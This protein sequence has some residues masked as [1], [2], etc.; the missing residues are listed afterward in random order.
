MNDWLKAEMSN[1][2]ETVIPLIGDSVA[3]YCR[4]RGDGKAWVSDLGS[5]DS[6]EEEDGLFWESA[7]GIDS[8]FDGMKF[9]DILQDYE[10]WF[11]PVP[12][13]EAGRFPS[14]MTRPVNEKD[15]LTVFDTGLEV[16]ELL[17]AGGEEKGDEYGRPDFP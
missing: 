7:F 15:G 13:L 16:Q 9:E 17:S 4:P 11:A 12:P 6:F 3:L 2:C 10:V 5:V 8:D 14:S 1:G